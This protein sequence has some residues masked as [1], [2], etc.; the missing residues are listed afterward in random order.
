MNVTAL[1]GIKVLSYIKFYNE[2]L[3]INLLKSALTLASYSAVYN[4]ISVIPLTAAS[5]WSFI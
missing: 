4:Y 3:D 1:V 2:Y 5:S